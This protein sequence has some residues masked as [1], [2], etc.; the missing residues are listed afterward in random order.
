MARTPTWRLQASA[1]AGKL[2]S[3]AL[4]MAHHAGG[5]GRLDILHGH[6]AHLQTKPSHHSAATP[7][8]ALT[9]SPPRYRQRLPREPGPVRRAAVPPLLPR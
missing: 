9:C 6:P 8:L 3:C 2:L 5:L 1:A 4:C 7:T